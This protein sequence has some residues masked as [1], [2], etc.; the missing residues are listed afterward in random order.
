MYLHT[1]IHIAAAPKA[2]LERERERERM[3][4]PKGARRQRESVKRHFFARTSRVYV[5][6]SRVCIYGMHVM[7]VGTWDVSRETGA[8]K[9]R[10]VLQEEL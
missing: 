6:T 1:H 2:S 5:Y 9:A 4:D 8:L 3:G 7:Y 10:R